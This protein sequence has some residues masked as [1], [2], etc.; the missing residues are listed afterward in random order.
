MNFFNPV[1]TTSFAEKIDRILRTV[2][3]ICDHTLVKSAAHNFHIVAY[4]YAWAVSSLK[5]SRKANRAVVEA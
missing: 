5:F 4:T 1:E 3:S 2:S